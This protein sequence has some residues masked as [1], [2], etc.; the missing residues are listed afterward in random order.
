MLSLARVENILTM[1]HDLSVGSEI[2]LVGQDRQFLMQ[3]NRIKSKIQGGYR[4]LEVS[5]IFWNFYLTCIMYI[6]MHANV[7]WLLTS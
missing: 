2:N 3:Q 4:V 6:Y 7:Y 5:M 1:S